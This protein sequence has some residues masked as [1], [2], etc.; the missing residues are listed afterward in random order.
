MRIEV[1]SLSEEKPFGS[2]LVFCEAFGEGYVLRKPDPVDGFIC[3]DN[4]VSQSVRSCCCNLSSLDWLL[5]SLFRFLAQSLVI[6]TI[7]WACQSR[8]SVCNHAIHRAVRTGSP[9]AFT[10]LRGPCSGHEIE[11][12]YM[13]CDQVKVWLQLL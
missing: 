2:H 3:S 1:L 5:I 11:F 6:H 7:S 8:I 12:S 4:P 9:R 13:F 10:T